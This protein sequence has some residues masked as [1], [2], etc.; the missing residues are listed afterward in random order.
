MHD[1]IEK[2]RKLDAEKRINKT[3]FHKMIGVSRDT[4]YNFLDGENVTTETLEAVAGG[5]KKIE[6][7]RG[8]IINE[9]IPSTGGPDALNFDGEES[10][11]MLSVN[12]K[13]AANTAFNIMR[14][15]TPF[16][17]RM[18]QA[19][20]QINNEFTEAAITS[21]SKGRPWRTGTEGER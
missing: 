16:A 6:A 8:L 21:A 1:L 2:F 5:L 4:L 10:C 7:E 12:I 13:S 14:S 11:K 9:E 15:G 19:I 18:Y 17:E 20:C 3:K